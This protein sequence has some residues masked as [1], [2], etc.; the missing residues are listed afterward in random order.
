MDNCEDT[1]WCSI[2]LSFTVLEQRGYADTDWDLYS[3]EIDSRTVLWT[4]RPGKK[5]VVELA[6]SVTDG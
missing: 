1:C 3:Y 5:S 4:I 6:R 2:L